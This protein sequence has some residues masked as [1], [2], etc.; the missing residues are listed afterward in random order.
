MEIYTVPF[1]YGL[2]V[3]RSIFVAKYSR[4]ILW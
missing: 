1:T 3:L 2:K 4:N